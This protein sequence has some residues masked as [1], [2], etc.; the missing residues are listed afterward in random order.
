[1]PP[2]KARCRACAV[3]PAHS[4]WASGGS[5]G[6]KSPDLFR[7]RLVTIKEGKRCFVLRSEIARP[8]RIWCEAACCGH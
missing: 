8:S 5:T 1:M 2:L 6:S 3:A 4:W 7:D